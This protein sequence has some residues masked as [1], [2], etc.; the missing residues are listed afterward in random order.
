MPGMFNVEQIQHGHRKKYNVVL[1]KYNMVT[2][3]NIAT[4]ETSQDITPFHFFHN[5]NFQY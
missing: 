5:F 1:N 2:E 3:K 4:G